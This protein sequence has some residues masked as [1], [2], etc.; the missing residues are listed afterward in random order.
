MSQRKDPFG[1]ALM[2]YL[3]GNKK[4]QITVVS[5]IVEDDFIPV[6]YLFR[7]YYQMPP[8][9]KRAL[10]MCKGKI[11]DVGAGSGCHSLYLQSEGY[12][13]TALEKSP[14]AAEVIRKQGLFKVEEIDFF[15]FEAPNKYN[16][17][18]L[19]MNGLGIAQTLEKFPEFLQ[20]CKSLLAPGGQIL[21]DSSDIKYLFE[22][23]DGSFLINI[24]DS[25]YGEV[26][27]QMVYE[28]VKGPKFDWLFLDFDLLSHYA[29]AHGMTA[30]KIAD[31]SH[32]DY[33][34]KLTLD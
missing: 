20:H 16:T 13:I 1:E 32:Y 6:N 33:L 18:L 30:T 2:S 24:N 23:E 7:R 29:E 21:L 10:S 12:D 11:L 26:E 3:N 22:E 15:K 4:G 14:L 9:E 25:Y 28:A 31:G 5:D 27:Y 19:L 17:L 8:L 34:A